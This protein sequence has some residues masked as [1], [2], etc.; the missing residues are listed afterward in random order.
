VKKERGDGAGGECHVKWPVAVSS[1]SSVLRTC[2]TV[3]W[4]LA[5]RASYL[6]RSEEASLALV[7]TVLYVP[8]LR[9][10]RGERVEGAVGRVKT[11][12]HSLIMSSG[13]HLLS[14]QGG[15]GCSLLRVHQPRIQ[16]TNAL[17]RTT[18]NRTYY[19]S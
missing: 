8:V 16:N 1:S 10:V 7:F 2:C 11:T 19:V 3:L 5:S 13:I 14:G 15:S 6:V 4:H 12:L 18:V 17:L 9:T